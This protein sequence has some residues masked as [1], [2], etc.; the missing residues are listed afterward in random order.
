MIFLQDTY[1][2]DP[3][4]VEYLNSFLLLPVSVQWIE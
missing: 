3:T 4:F 2:Q 1:L